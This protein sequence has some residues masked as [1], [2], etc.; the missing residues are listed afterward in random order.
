MNDNIIP[1]KCKCNEERKKLTKAFKFFPGI[2]GMYIK[3]K[4]SLSFSLILLSIFERYI[5]NSLVLDVFSINFSTTLSAPAKAEYVSIPNIA[6]L[7][8]QVKNLTSLNSL[9]DC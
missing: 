5:K 4:L 9:Y 7:A 1:F 3:S 8:F 2:V 6:I